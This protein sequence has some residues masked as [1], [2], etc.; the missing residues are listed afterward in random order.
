LGGR[1]GS[2][3]SHDPRI[4]IGREGPIFTMAMT[5]QEAVA[6]IPS[7]R[8]AS[9]LTVAPLAG[10]LTNHTF[11]VDVDAESFA[12]RIWTPGSERLGIDRQREHR[13]MLAASRAGIAPDVIAFLPDVGITVTRF[14]AGV[15]LAPGE[16]AGPAVVKR[17]VR[18]IRRCH[19]GPAFE[20]TCRPARTLAR[21]R[22]VAQG[23]GVPLPE[24]L[25][26]LY[27]LLPAI[28]QALGRRPLRP[29]HHDLWGPNLIDD[30]RQVW[31]VDWEYAGMGDVYFDLANF[32]MHHAPG[33]GREAVLRAYFGEVSAA[34][35]ARLTLM[36][37]IAEL[38][39]A[40]WYEVALTLPTAMP[41][42]AD[43][44]A[45]HFDRCRRIAGDG[46]LPA[47][48]ALATGE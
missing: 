6:C 1:T 16:R 9:S 15:G 45:A 27:G 34:A 37:I 4:H 47:W 44:A 2:T 41:D 7:W 17:V 39:E 3:P 21:Y 14:V 31:I 28:E 42:F 33:E 8:R 43:R 36:E 19:D 46:R 18:S 25:D 23:Q 11:R 48:L 22:R 24:D 12:V 35:L 32:A 30:G 20:G 5:I 13:C 38:R 26:D 29:C 10:G 40:M